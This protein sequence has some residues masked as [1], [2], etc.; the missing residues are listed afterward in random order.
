VSQ[1]AYSQIG[2]LITGSRNVCLDENGFGP[3]VAMAGKNSR[4]LHVWSP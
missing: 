3:D 2:H 4:Q 1:I